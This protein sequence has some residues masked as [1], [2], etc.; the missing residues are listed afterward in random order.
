MTPNGFKDASTDSAVIK[1][2]W[3][4][5]PDAAIGIPTGE[6]SGLVVVDIDDYK[7]DFDQVAWDAICEKIGRTA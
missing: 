3:E 1:I 4:N 2:W 5:N 6:I 7:E